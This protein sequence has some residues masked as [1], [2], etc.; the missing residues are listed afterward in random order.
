[1]QRDCVVK[2]I[3]N[4]RL[5]LPERFVRLDHMPD[6]NDADGTRQSVGSPNSIG[7]VRTY[8]LNEGITFVDYFTHLRRRILLIFAWMGVCLGLSFLYLS[9]ARIEYSATAQ[10]ALESRLR[11]P[12]GSDPSASALSPTLDSAQAES[13]VQVIKS[14]SNLQYVFDSLNLEAL[15]IGDPVTPNFAARMLGFLLP[16]QEETVEQI[17]SKDRLRREAA[18]NAFSNQVAVRRLGQSY[19]LEITYRATTAEMASKVANSIAASYIR[20]QIIYRGFSDQRSS[21]FLQ[22]RIS[23]LQSQRASRLKQYRVGSYQMYN[24]PTRTL[25]SLVRHY[26]H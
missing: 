17:K 18:F 14:I 25:V 26:C 7:S 3:P 19:I 6:L 21:D 24:F 9:Y 2:N 11:L 13:Q 23:S 12:P 5:A 1:M 16:Q 10:I 8:Q 22:G 15:F 4:H 20:G